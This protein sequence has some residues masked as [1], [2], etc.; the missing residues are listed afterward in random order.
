MNLAVADV[1]DCQDLLRYI[2]RVGRLDRPDS[3]H[4]DLAFACDR[5]ASACKQLYRLSLI[6][7]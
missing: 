3:D 1:R 5:D 6:I 4:H 2:S 7:K